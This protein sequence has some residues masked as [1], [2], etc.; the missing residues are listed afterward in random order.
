MRLFVYNILWFKVFD[1]VTKNC[2][3]TIMFPLAFLAAA[4]FYFFA[5]SPLCTCLY[6]ATLIGALSIY[7]SLLL[8]IWLGKDEVHSDV[9]QYGANVPT[10]IVY[11][12]I[13]IPGVVA[14][15]PVKWFTLLVWAIYFVTS[16]FLAT[17]KPKVFKTSTENEDEL[18]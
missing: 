1:F 8:T 14:G 17:Y 18:G 15:G 12:L 4:A 11:T 6:V 2:K 13:F 5:P 10:I 16:Y 7:S 3:T 9:L